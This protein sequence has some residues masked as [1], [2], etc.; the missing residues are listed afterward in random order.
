MST[1]TMHFGPEWMRAKP[2]P[3]SRAQHPPS[4]PPTAPSASGA[5]TYSATVS[6]APPTQ[7]EKHDETHPF[8]YTKEDLLRIY[9][10]GGGKGGLGLEVERW[11]GV[12]R[13][14]GSEP[15]GL[16]EITET[17]KKLF[18]GSLNSDI[19]RR[20]STDYLSPL[21]TTLGGPDRSRLNHGNTAASGSPLRE[22]FNL[23]RRDSTDSPA[24]PIPR[25][26]SLSSLQ[27]PSMSPRDTGLPSPRTR[28]GISPGFD[29]VLNSGES[30]VSRRRASE[31]S[32]KA[33]VGTAREGG[34][35]QHEGK[36][37]EIREEEE[38][39]AA[40]LQ[41]QRL[42]GGGGSSGPQPQTLDKQRPTDPGVTQH[43]QSDPSVDGLNSG[44]AQM[45]V[46]M[47]SPGSLNASPGPN[48][49]AAN[50]PDP[51]TIKWSYKD[52][53]GQVQG[54][55]PAEL[56]QKWHDDGY[57]TP[58]LPMKRIDI[59]AHWS[60]L[61]ELT[62]RTTGEKIFLSPILAHAPPGLT[63]PV[64]SPQ[65]GFSPAIEQQ[66][67]F[68]AP[69]QPAPIRSLR[70]STLDSYLGNGSNPSDS[71]SSSFGAGRFSNGSPDPNAFGG[72]TSNPQYGDPYGARN[73]A[74]G[75]DVQHAFP[76]RRNTFSDSPLDP[77]TN[78][79]GSPF[80]GVIPGRGPGVDGFGYNNYGSWN[81][82]GNAG[83]NYDPHTPSRATSD[84]FTI[85]QEANHQLGPLDEKLPTNYGNYNNLTNNI[86]PNAHQHQFTPSGQFIPQHHTPSGP[87]LGNAYNPQYNLH[88][89]QQ[90]AAPSPISPWSVPEARRPGP[91]DTQHPTAAPNPVPQPAPVPHQSPWGRS[92]QQP[93]QP[94]QQQA[95]RSEDVSPWFAA[96][97]GIVDD[98]WKEPPS[99]LTVDNVGQHNQQQAQLA[100]LQQQAPQHVEPIVTESVPPPAPA[101]SAP[102]EIQ[103]PLRETILAPPT[104]SRAK[105]TAQPAQ[106]PPPKVS[107][108]T[109]APAP[110]AQEVLS[111]SPPPPKAAWS[112]EDRSGKPSGVTMSLRDIQ[113]AEA[114][115]VE[116]RKVTER[117]REKER[118][119]R[120][121]SENSKED[122]QTFTTSWGLPSSQVGSRA[123]Q[124]KE[125]PSTTTG[126]AVPAPVWTTAAK[127]PV[128]KKSM[129]EIQEEEERR[130]KQQVAKESIATAAARR[131]YAES[132]NKAP[133]VAAALQP[134]TNN[135]WS[136][137]G[138]SG[139]VNPT[140]A[141]TRPVVASTSSSSAITTAVRVNG[142]AAPRPVSAASPAV[143]APPPKPEEP[144]APQPPSHEFVKWLNDSLKGLNSSVN[145]EEIM[146]MLLSFPLDDSSTAEI[147]S[148]L[149]YA[150][151][152]TLDGRRYASEFINKRRADA[153]AARTRNTTGGPASKL[154][155]KPVSI[156]D[157]VKA[158]PKQQAQAELGF[159]VVKK[160]KGGRS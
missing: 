4:P 57:F 23:R 117:E 82:S 90:H 96:S 12:V 10:E 45:S 22:R 16:R 14:I 141:Q 104:K 124:P 28:V 113:E 74:Y 99:S 55:F 49:F 102:S 59:D 103:S 19:R 100:A 18:A 42:R 142:S 85:R 152:T 159:K 121:A 72:R 20:Q 35:Y 73:P 5:S 101:P 94:A 9:R 56:M 105:T 160:K 36:A 138:P 119:A 88:N 130:K 3:Q 13:E 8:R 67:P 87:S 110:I 33:G 133:A 66:S 34:D 153:A 51:A 86:P 143:K 154:P 81:Q 125:T 144:I 79:R 127:A 91:L 47:N 6:S 115:K 30:W 92:T 60:P 97:Q 31:A 135:P 140:P 76:G 38:E 108:P 95:P 71:P 48:S 52:P 148:D 120:L 43:G 93:P 139:K 63:R 128:V 98:A 17:E 157:V 44:M 129:K 70:S 151:S 39:D 29:G 53:S 11:E 106:Q 118:S 77:S 109:A 75:G 156:A 78:V 134:A 107:P 58:D 111:P 116:A 64:E 62:R 149:I 137:V 114:K 145:V 50:Y 26:Q 155:A 123:P 150:N 2:Q 84:P 158:T 126:S 25:K 61:E 24:L 147:I 132:S 46:G 131:A 32:L 1:T 112:T 37:T 83:A 7:P 80:A 89:I 122:I 27:P 21:S 69:Y 41:Q 68:N 146:S 136:T 40:G 65:Q 15:I 54:P